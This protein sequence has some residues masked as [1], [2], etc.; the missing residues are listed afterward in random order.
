MGD[1]VGGGVCVVFV[2]RDVEWAI[3]ICDNMR[4]VEIVFFGV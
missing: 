1:V 4:V 3:N 2:Y